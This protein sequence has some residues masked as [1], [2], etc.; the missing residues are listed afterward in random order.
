METAVVSVGAYRVR[1]TVNQLLV[2]LVHNRFVVIRVVRPDVQID[3]LGLP[4][5]LHLIG[6]EHNRFQIRITLPDLVFV[7][8]LCH[9]R[10]RR[11]GRLV[12]GHVAFVFPEPALA[13]VITHRQL[14]TGNPV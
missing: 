4:R 7:N 2:R 8:L 3:V 13:E 5:E 10:H 9:V 1:L 6:N 12:T 14:R 11:K